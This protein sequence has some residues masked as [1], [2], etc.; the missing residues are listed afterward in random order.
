MNI[1]AKIKLDFSAQFT[2]YLNKID[3]IEHLCS[4]IYHYI[5]VYNSEPYMNLSTFVRFI[6]FCN[7]SH[8]LLTNFENITFNGIKIKIKEDVEDD[9]MLFLRKEID[10]AN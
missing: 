8:L 10:D 6:N 9:Y 2:C 5:R 4:N 7:P 1:I 3:A